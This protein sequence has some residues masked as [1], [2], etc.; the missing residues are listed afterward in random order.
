MKNKFPY[1]L[2]LSKKKIVKTN[3]FYFYI[4]IVIVFNIIISN[5]NELKA[6]CTNPRIN[7][8]SSTSM[9]VCSGVS[10]SFY[11][12]A[13]LIGAAKV[14][15]LPDVAND[16]WTGSYTFDASNG[17]TIKTTMTFASCWFCNDHL[18]GKV[19][20]TLSLPPDF[21]GNTC[22]QRIEY[23]G[24]GKLFRTNCEPAP[25]ITYLPEDQ[26]RYQPVGSSATAPIGT[27]WDLEFDIPPR[28]QV[29]DVR[30]AVG[31][32][33]CGFGSCEW[34]DMQWTNTRVEIGNNSI[35]GYRWWVD[36]DM[37]KN[38][39]GSADPKDNTFDYT[40]DGAPGTEFNL[41]MKVYT[42][43][44]SC[45]FNKKVTIRKPNVNYIKCATTTSLPGGYT[46]AGSELDA[47][48]DITATCKSAIVLT[49]NFNNSTT[50]AGESF[51]IGTTDIVWTA[52]DTYGTILKTKTC[53]IEVIDMGLPC[54]EDIKVENLTTAYA[55][56]SNGTVKSAEAPTISIS[57]VKPES[58]G[59]VTFTAKTPVMARADNVNPPATKR[60]ERT[61]ISHTY[62]WTFD[63]GTKISQND[64]GSNSSAKY[65]IGEH[66]N[67]KAVKCEVTTKIL[68]KP[69]NINLPC[70]CSDGCPEGHNAGCWLGP[71]PGHGSTTT[72]TTDA[73]GNTTTTTTPNPC[74]CPSICTSDHKKHAIGTKH[75]PNTCEEEGTAEI[76]TYVT[77]LETCFSIYPTDPEISVSNKKANTTPGKCYYKSH[78]TY[79][80]A[81]ATSCGDN[82]TLTNDKN[83]NSS[84]LNAIFDVGTHTVNWSVQHNQ[85]PTSDQKAQTIKIRDKEAPK[86]Y[87]NN[88]TRAVDNNGSPITITTGD[89]FTGANDNCSLNGSPWL[90]RYNFGCNDVLSHNHSVTVYHKDIYDNT[91]STSKT[92]R[93]NDNI[94]PTVITKDIEV[95]LDANGHY[96]LQPNEVDNGSSDNCTMHKTVSPNAFDCNT[97]ISQ[98]SPEEYTDVNV[99]L[100][101]K[102]NQPNTST[103]GAVVR[104]R[105]VLPPVI[106]VQNFSIELDAVGEAVVFL[107][108]INIA[109]ADNCA[110]KG[111]ATGGMYLSS[112]METGL[113]DRL[114]FDCMS[115]GM[116]NVTF[117]AH[118]I[119]G[120]I[121]TQNVQ[122][123]VIDRVPPVAKCKA[124]SIEIQAS[125]TIEEG[126]ITVSPS[127]IDNGSWDNCYIDKFYSAKTKFTCDDIGDNQVIMTVVDGYGNYAKCFSNVKVSAIKPQIAVQ[128]AS[129]A[130]CETDTAELAMSVN[131]N[132]LINYQWHQ[133]GAV[134]GDNRPNITGEDTRILKINGAKTINAGNYYCLTTIACSE[135]SYTATVKVNKA[136]KITAQPKNNAINLGWDANVLYVVSENAKTYQWYHN[137]YEIPGATG[138]HYTVETKKENEGKYKCILT[139]NGGCQEESQEA[140]IIV[141]D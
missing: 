79:F 108:D 118:D 125:G 124:V 84:L 93:I 43:T 41:R 68:L 129:I 140:V 32:S 107:S 100:T 113:N 18:G 83:N 90:S 39:C 82:H 21:E 135:K 123:E 3:K 48:V 97:V 119:H 73:D 27:S 115:T 31:F 128:P 22:T 30:V 14:V 111:D 131:Y 13:T 10:T 104:V 58:C 1:L 122:I 114:N 96:S 6:Q 77:S 62:K 26:Q 35:K 60:F 25:Y 76:K 7:G 53:P 98:A 120:N 89:M 33:R 61:L 75:E 80:D 94:S 121:S 15:N 20:L 127:F 85:F 134:I 136:V 74:T 2:K 63:Y 46:V 19:F 133:A 137:G 101:V 42:K 71:C 106:D 116:N 28:F 52:T 67:N 81:S 51:P 117:T 66:F 44:G 12:K 103:L 132:G 72:T 88:I 59:E 78:N 139:T 92:V 65:E 95:E 9:K 45:E 36:G 99:I 126:T 86:V 49:N 38:T 34:K 40:F 17:G 55:A 102:D 5:N 105:D 50:L 57:P 24:D 64:V 141:L 29:P 109:T 4:F 56:Q 8:S 130:I 11:G 69:F 138:S 112:D 110:M 70:P 37:K 87:A 54:G 23:H 16:H 91:G 47:T